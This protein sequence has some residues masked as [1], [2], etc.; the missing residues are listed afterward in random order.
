[1]GAATYF[2]LIHLICVMTDCILTVVSSITS[3]QKSCIMTGWYN[4]PLTIWRLRQERS[5]AEVHTGCEDERNVQEALS[6]EGSSF[7]LGLIDSSSQVF[8]VLQNHLV[9]F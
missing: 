9:R 6:G 5:A 4:T 2:H 7:Q 8:A 3:S 1:M